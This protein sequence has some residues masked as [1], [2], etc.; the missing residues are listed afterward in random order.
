MNF[1]SLYN[2]CDAEEEPWEEAEEPQED[3]TK[4]ACSAGDLSALEHQ[5]NA[6][7]ADHQRKLR[8][9]ISADAPHLV[10]KKSAPRRAPPA[11]AP[12]AKPSRSSRRV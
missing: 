5:R 4:A 1:D 6:N 2:T 9:L 3:L 12:P 7:N 11:A 10:R 8:E